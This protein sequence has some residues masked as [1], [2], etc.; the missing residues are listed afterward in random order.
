MPQLERTK[1]KKSPLVKS[2]SSDSINYH[3]VRSKGSKTRLNGNLKMTGLT[4][5]RSNPGYTIRS[6]S[7]PKSYASSMVKKKNKVELDLFA[8]DNDSDSDNSQTKDN[9]FESDDDN[10]GPD[11]FEDYESDTDG[12]EEEEQVIKKGKQ[13]NNGIEEAN[14]KE[15]MTSEDDSIKDEAETS[16]HGDMIVPELSKLAVSQKDLKEIPEDINH[17]LNH[18]HQISEI[19]NPQ[20]NSKAIGED[21]SVINKAEELQGMTANNNE[22]LTDQEQDTLTYLTNS[23]SAGHLDNVDGNESENSDSDSS[24][25]SDEEHK[26]EGAEEGIAAEEEERPEDEDFTE[27]SYQINI[28]NPRLLS[29]RFDK[30]LK[31]QRESSLI[32]NNDGTA[33]PTLSSPEVGARNSNKLFP[34]HNPGNNAKS[35]KQWKY[36]MQYTETDLDNSFFNL[37]GAKKPAFEEGNTTSKN[38][39]AKLNTRGGLGLAINNVY[40]D[41]PIDFDNRYINIR[42]LNDELYLDYYNLRNFYNPLI[43]SVKDIYNFAK[44]EEKLNND[45]ESLFRSENKN[46]VNIRSRRNTSHSNSSS[47]NQLQSIQSNISSNTTHTATNK[48]LRNELMHLYSLPNDGGN[49]NNSL[50]SNNTVKKQRKDNLLIYEYENELFGNGPSVVNNSSIKQKQKSKKTPTNLSKKHITLGKILVRDSGNLKLV[51]QLFAKQ[52]EKH[53]KENMITTKVFQQQLVNNNPSLGGSNVVPGNVGSSTPNGPLVMQRNM[54]GQ[55]RSMQR[56]NSGVVNNNVNLI[57]GHQQYSQTANQQQ[58]PLTKAQ[59]QQFLKEREQQRQMQLLQQQKK[60]QKLEAQ[61]QKQQELAA[62]QADQNRQLNQKQQY[63]DIF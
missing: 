1:K 46:N 7:N 49:D 45:S 60:Q 48:S 29:S 34:S 52:M 11:N 63:G 47:F 53:Q 8:R 24:T 31:L 4:K 20:G 16:E 19:N 39:G 5:V 61:Q 10:N 59:Y 6:N 40:G 33:I 58:P 41:E 55:P 57:Q 14:T 2:R 30:K 28:P 23:V 43:K 27:R 32:V 37:Q 9:D 56:I 62:Q 51:N 50:F 44:Y 35:T 26:P 22:L 15:K 21:L 18:S 3:P 38:G 12:K 13:E 54:G 17:D 25:S 42:K 36:S